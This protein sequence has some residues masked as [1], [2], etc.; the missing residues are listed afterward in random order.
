MA[1]AF[2]IGQGT[3]TG[4]AAPGANPSVGP[5][6]GPGPTSSTQIGDVVAGVFTPFS[7]TNP[8][9]VSGT[10]TA[11]NP[12]VGA[13]GVAAPAF[14]TEI[15]IIDASGHLVGSSA[16]NPVRIDP[17]GTTVQPVSGTV[18]ALQGTSPWVVSGT[19]TITPSGLQ[20]VN[21]TQ[22]DSVALGAP[23]A[24]GTS[25][26]AVNVIGVNAFITNTVP[27]TLASTTITGNV[28][29][30]QPTGTNLHVVIDSGS[31]ITAAITGQSA[32]DTALV[33]N[34][35]TVSGVDA[36]GNVQELPVADAGTAV[37]AQT[38][39]VGG[40]DTSGNTQQIA[41]DTTGGVA[42]AVSFSAQADAQSNA[43][44]LTAGA[45]GI[46][47]HTLIFPYL[48]NGT[49]WDRQRGSVNL[50]AQGNIGFINSSPSLFNG[51]TWDRARSAGVGNN[52]AATG[53]AASASYGNVTTAAPVYTTGTYSAL[54][55]DTAGNLRVL[56]SPAAGTLST[57]VG[58]KSNNSVAPGATNLGVLPAIANAATQ[59]WTEGDQVL[60]SV[61]LSGRQRV[62]GTIAH[63]TQAPDATGQMCLT[64]LANAVAPTYTEGNLV[65]G[66]VDLSGNRRIIGTKTNNNAAPGTQVAVLPALAN[67]AS[68]AWTE[69]NQVL[70]SVDLTGRQR[71][72]GT[73]TNNNAAPTADL[74]ENMPAIAT[75][76]APSYTTGNAV[77]LSTDLAGNLRVLTT[78]ATGTSTMVQ[79]MA[80]ADAAA[81]GNP[82]LVGGVDAAG[83]VQE[84]PVADTGTTA[85]AQTLVVGGVSI[86]GNAI[87]FLT[88]SSGQIAT[89]FGS[90]GADAVVNSANVAGPINGAG[91]QSA[92]WGVAPSLFN[93]TTWDR[94]RSAGVG[95]AQPSTG[96]A[97]EVAYGEYLSTA[98]APTTGQYSALQTDYA[99]CLFV[100]H[101]RRSQ[102][103]VKGTT[104]SNS[105]AA[106]TVVTAPGAGLFADLSSL[107][108]S[109]TPL[110][111]GVAPISFTATLS[112]G[113]NSFIYDLQATQIGTAV[114]VSNSA[115]PLIIEYNPSVPATTAA[116]AWTLQLSVATVT[117]HITTVAILQKAS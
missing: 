76:A 112:D 63:N 75:T 44:F 70:E 34:P 52:V 2:I 115:P 41:T 101:L 28:T 45:G 81:V 91:V 116:T 88:G 19:V 67:A 65:L 20:N 42:N 6:G 30:V 31:A 84:L 110:A 87:Q 18:T 33:G 24:Y 62:R 3:G 90:A 10:I 100:K 102:L 39:L 66:S 11:T 79:G 94:A 86:A 12:S 9:P 21:V 7:P 8:V 35:V 117:V 89:A 105:A 22:W 77:M 104:I 78:P 47:T 37:P 54:S 57:V 43:A 80:A 96:L 46:I 113:T 58:N 32:P 1:N 38:V 109:V 82:V 48:F 74:I 61:D 83:N 60:E 103:V 68:P 107:L 114:L 73:L 98:P 108:I 26:G 16:S 29:V 85:P 36:A 49:T 4:A 59:T 50:D 40:K 92:F 25:P 111:A 64:E 15:G 14:A 72:R 71:V 106:T 5:N 23:S 53:I 93:G 69:G 51:I 55:L 27:V 95:N 97:A 56:T 99:G 17:T 13:T